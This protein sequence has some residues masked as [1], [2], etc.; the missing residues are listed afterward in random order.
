MSKI[1]EVAR[2]IQTR[3]E[4]LPFSDGPS[5]DAAQYTELARAAIEAM[6]D[7]TVK[8]VREGNRATTD[9]RGAEESWPV[10]IDAALNE[11]G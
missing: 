4:N 1:E 3:L 9:G 7:P 10:M 8:M 6:R 2:A 11:E 5:D